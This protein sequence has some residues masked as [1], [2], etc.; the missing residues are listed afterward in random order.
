MKLQQKNEY[1]AAGPSGD[2]AIVGMS[3]F[4]P[5]ADS[6]EARA[7]IDESKKTSTKVA[8]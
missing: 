5:G 1:H 7:L 8:E 6:A 3:V 4:V 2:I